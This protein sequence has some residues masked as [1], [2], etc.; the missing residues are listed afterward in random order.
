[1][2]NTYTA[3]DM[4]EDARFRREVTTA[5]LTIKEVFHVSLARLEGC[6]LNEQ[7][8]F[9]AVGSAFCDIYRLRLFRGI[10]QEDSHK[11]AAFLVK[12]LVKFLPIQLKPG[13][14]PTKILLYVNEILAISTSIVVLGFSQ[15]NVFTDAKWLKYVNNMMYLLKFHSCSGERMASEMFLLDAL[16][17]SNYDSNQ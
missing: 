16:L 17:R 1:M 12:W 14:P 5:F 8:L 7:I 2:P 4:F 9:N 3:K 10:E 15:Q 11:R 6:Y 13:V